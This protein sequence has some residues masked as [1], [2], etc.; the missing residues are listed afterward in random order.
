VGN[1]CVAC[2]IERRFAPLS[3]PLESGQTVEV[4]TAPGAVPN[5]SWLS[6][7]VT[8][9]ARAN[10]RAYL[11]HLQDAEAIRL[12]HRLLTKAMTAEGCDIDELDEARID[13]LLGEYHQESFNDL[14]REIGLG[15][16]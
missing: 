16:R 10:I 12:G 15:N 6:F 5:P 8:A 2:K 4:I 1:T 13:R 3:T 9:R 14:L 11:K 7:V